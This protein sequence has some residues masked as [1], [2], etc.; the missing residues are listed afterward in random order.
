MGL[1]TDRKWGIRRVLNTLDLNPEVESTGI[2]DD[3][4]AAAWGFGTALPT[5]AEAKWPGRSFFHTTERTWYVCDHNGQW[6]AVGG[7][8]AVA[9]GTFGTVAT[10]YAFENTE[11]ASYVYRSGKRVDIRLRI[12][13]SS[14]ALSHGEPVFTTSSAYRP[15]GIGA[16]PLAAIQAGG[17]A[18]ASVVAAVLNQSGTISPLSP[19]GVSTTLEVSG[20]FYLP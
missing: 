16:W 2:R 1:G 5:A 12:K 13:R 19:S 7:Q 18:S 17:A 11:G 10:G 4:G 20:A 14:G 9:L 8:Y 6:L 15:A 3:I